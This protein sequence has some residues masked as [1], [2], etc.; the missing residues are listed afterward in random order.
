MRIRT[1]NAV[2]LTC[3]RLKLFVLIK[4]CLS[5]VGP[6][7]YRYVAGTC[8]RFE[9]LYLFAKKTTW[10]SAASS[11][12]CAKFVFYDNA[13]LQG[14]RKT[15]EE[16][17]ET[18]QNGAVR[19][20]NVQVFQWIYDDYPFALNLEAFVAA[21]EGGYTRVLEWGRVKGYG[22]VLLRLICRNSAAKG[23]LSVVEW[24]HQRPQFNCAA[25]CFDS[26]SASERPCS[27]AA[28]DERQ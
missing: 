28:M 7:H 5:F 19:V 8:R 17:F 2:D 13:L 9:K 14:E 10:K 25:T 11:V 12:S 20:G 15:K 18:L 3:R 1:P 26:G 22:L 16:V 23:H 24:I 4:A 27:C 6:G 21:G